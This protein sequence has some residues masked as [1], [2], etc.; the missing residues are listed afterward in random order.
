[1]ISLHDYGDSVDKV[2]DEITTTKNHD[3]CIKIKQGICY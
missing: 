1:M 2:Q 3:Q